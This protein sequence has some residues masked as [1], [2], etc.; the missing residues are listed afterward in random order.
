MLKLKSRK[1]IKS[2]DQYITQLKENKKIKSRINHT[3]M[4]N[5]EI[6]KNKLKITKNKLSQLELTC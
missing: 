5:D 4:L 6:E 1:K 3:L 2:Q